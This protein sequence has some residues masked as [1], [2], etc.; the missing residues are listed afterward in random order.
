[1]KIIA[2][3]ALTAGGKTTTVNILK[4]IL[5]DAKSLHFDDYEFEG[6]V[7]DYYKWVKEGA[8]YNAWNLK[9]ML[10]D[11]IKIKDCGKYKY[12]LLDYP[13]AY[14]NDMLKKYIDLAVFIDTPLDIALARGI[15][16]DMKDSDA[17]EIRNWLKTY[18]DHSRIAFIQMLKDIR[19]SSDYIVD[20]TMESAKIAYKIA[21][22]IKLIN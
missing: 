22:Y 15:L 6:Q 4:D 5:P 3:G 21:E 14:R 16:R 18:L 7:D 12:L 20:G 19:P 11:I 13:F 9:P 2:I 17:D 10:D 1:M 8:N